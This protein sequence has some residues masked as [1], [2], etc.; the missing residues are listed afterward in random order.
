[1]RRVLALSLFASFLCAQQVRVDQNRQTLQLAS[2]VVLTQRN[3]AALTDEK[4]AE[5]DKLLGEGRGHLAA[6]RQGEARRILAQAGAVMAGTKWD[7]NEIY[8][9]SLVLRTNTSVLDPSRPLIV[10]LTQ[11]YPASIKAAQGLRL[12]ASLHEIQGQGRVSRPGK[13]V[14]DFGILD[15]VSRDLIEEPYTFDLDLAGLPEGNYMLV[16]GPMDFYTPVRDLGIRIAVVADFD[17]HRAAVEQ[18]LKKVP[19]HDSAKAT[20]RYPFDLARQVNA[21]RREFFPLDYPKD[22]ARSLEIVKNLEA[23]KDIV[24]K[25][26]G[27]QARHYYFAAADEVM[28]Y[29]LYVPAK[30]DGKAKLP[31]I[32]TLHGLGGTED[33]PLIRDDKLAIQ[34][35]EKHGFIV[36]SPLG[37][38]TNGAYGNHSAPT[39]PDPARARV[40]ELSE[41]DALNVVD[42]VAKEYGTDPTRTFLMGHSMGGGGTWYLGQ[43]YPKKWRALGPIAA[44]AVLPERYPWDKMKDVPMI[45]AHGDKDPTV[46]VI[47]SRTMTEK[48]RAAGLA[49]EYLEIPGANHSDIVPKSLPK[50]YEFFAKYLN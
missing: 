40:L 6:G 44:P 19:G 25:A 17:K 9:S 12:H 24:E 2:V 39:P 21:G 27:E 37:Y 10:T 32:L 22:I 35:A 49:P 13:M 11:V 34:L 28:P 20:A 7:E 36:V 15:G 16:A 43:K 23:A 30:Y 33:G 48:A 41:Q 4:K 18:R 3:S 8:A 5:V 42:L 45:V 26:K 31:L 1:M 14:R 38:R 29:R 46:P 47:A 50:I